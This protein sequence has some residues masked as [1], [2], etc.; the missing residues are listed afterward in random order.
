VT[1]HLGRCS[2]P[3]AALTSMLHGFRGESSIPGNRAV[4]RERPRVGRNPQ[5]RAR[6]TFGLGRGVLPN[7]PFGPLRATSSDT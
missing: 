7:E 3:V 4:S 5:G 1:G 2:D 6:L